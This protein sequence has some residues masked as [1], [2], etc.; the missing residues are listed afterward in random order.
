MSSARALFARGFVLHEVR[1]VSSI[2]NLL[3]SLGVF[4]RK[5]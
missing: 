2:P 3:S 1:Q 5:V 4:R